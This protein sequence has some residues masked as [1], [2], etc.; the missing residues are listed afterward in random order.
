MRFMRS[1]TDKIGRGF[2]TKVGE[3]AKG[4]R[5]RCETRKSVGDPLRISR[6]E[7]LSHR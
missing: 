2:Y 5:E 1:E 4:K 7:G 6:R 3:T